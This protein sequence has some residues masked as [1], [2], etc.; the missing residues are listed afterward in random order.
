VLAGSVADRIG[1]RRVFQAGLALFTAASPPC[2][3][4]PSLGWL[5]VFRMVQAACGSMLNPV[6][7]S[8]ITNTFT[9]PRERT[10][11]IG[12]R[13]RGHRLQH[14]PRPGHRLQRGPRPGHRLQHAAWWILCGLGLAVLALGRFSTPPNTKTPPR[15]AEK[16]PS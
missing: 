13:G 4:A 9:D 12:V 15:Y 8:I 5:I 2:G 11:T 3:V 10:R 1:R 6:A 14:G 16:L 7:M